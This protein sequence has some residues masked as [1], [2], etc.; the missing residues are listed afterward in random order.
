[1]LEKSNTIYIPPY[2][3]NEINL[4]KATNKLSEAIIQETSYD[5][6]TEFK[7]GWLDLIWNPHEKDFNR[8][9]LNETL[10]DILDDYL[11]L[12]EEDII[13]LKFGFG[14]EY[15]DS[16][17]WQRPNKPLTVAKIAEVMELSVKQVRLRLDSAL[18]KLKTE[19]IQYKL[20]KWM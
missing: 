4:L 3:T 8:M 20:T 15:F 1:M 11:T 10:L 9:T 13:K 17:D 16:P 5:N 14:H 6:P 2:K 7:G 19:E 12:E 18:T